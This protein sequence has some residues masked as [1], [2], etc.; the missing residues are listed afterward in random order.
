MK[1]IQTIIAAKLTVV[2]S[3]ASKRTPIQMWEALTYKYV[4]IN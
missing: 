2:S 3:A 1:F 4:A